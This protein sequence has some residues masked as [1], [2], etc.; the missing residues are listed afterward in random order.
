MIDAAVA[1]VADPVS[2]AAAPGGPEPWRPGPPFSGVPAYQLCRAYTVTGDLDA[3]ALR[4]AWHTVAQRHTALRHAVAGRGGRASDPVTGGGGLAVARRGPDEH[5]VTLRLHQAVTDERSLAVMLGELSAHYAARAHGRALPAALAVWP[6]QYTDPALRH[7][8]P[9]GPRRRALLS[10]WTER[11]TP[12][13]AGLAIPTDRPRPRGA[14]TRGGTL[15]FDWGP[16]PAARLAALCERSAVTP[17]AVLLA[18]FQALLA[19]F[20]DEPRTAVGVPASL[21]PARPEA[22]GV[23]GPYRNHLV[24]STD[25]GGC[26]TFRELA[27]RVAQGVRAAFDH[28]ELPYEQLLREL[29]ADDDVRRR[30]P[31]CDALFVHEP[32]DTAELR[33]PGVRVRRRT[34]DNATARTDLTLTVCQD[35]PVLRGSL[36]YRAALW[37]PPSAAAL[38]E[39]LR[40]LLTAA[41]ERPD[42]PLGELPLESAQFLRGAVRAADRTAVPPVREPVHAQVYAAARR[43]PDATA[44]TGGGDTVS[45]AALRRRAR[46]VTEALTARG[47]A[48][49][50]VAVRLDNGPDQAATVLG[51]FAAGAHALCL[52]TGR[53]GERDRAVLTAAAPAC[54]VV[55][56]ARTDDDLV[57]WYQTAHHGQVLA[58]AALA[59]DESGAES[60]SG[61]PG[62][63][64]SGADASALDRWAYVTHTS[65][66]T[67]TPKGIP[68]THR[69][70]AQFLAWFAA[71]FRL[72]PGARMAQWAAPGYDASL[73]EMGA[74][75][76]SGA[77][78]CTVPDKI[79]AHPEKLA[80]WLAAERITHFQTVPSFARQLLTAATATT[81]GG[82][83]PLTGL[84]H[85]LLAGEALTGELAGGLRAA[86]PGVRLVNL[87]GATETIL[88]TWHEVTGP[89]HGPVPI[90]RSIP[91]RQVLVLDDADRPCPTGV[92]GHIVVRGPYLTPGYAGGAG[93]HDDAAFR[94]L[95]SLD[96]GDAAAGGRCYRSGDLGRRRRDGALEFRGR[97]DARVKFLGV[98][99]ELTDIEAALA[100]H[101]SVTDCAVVAL[102]GPDG[103]VSRLVAHV[104]PGR[105][106]G[107][108]P[109]GS[110]AEW[111]AVLRR[112]FG[113][114]M[115][116]VSF[117]TLTGLPRNTGGKVDRRRLAEAADASVPSAPPVTRSLTLLPT[118]S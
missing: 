83:T 14:A 61:T 79:R 93:P 84:S 71:E 110:A 6:R 101:P 27:D 28:R 107:G 46:A 75:L 16:G 8:A 40:T 41:L 116:P 39:Q 112:R 10:W 95:D 105:A 12:P 18:A 51:A 98:R 31:L 111:R 32:A 11:L 88:A 45:Y 69:T 48:G 53:S 67:G 97:A 108:E 90:G 20:A 117:T 115:L 59:A 81:G 50:A 104:V 34:V 35:S 55:D 73:V 1:P 63:T 36:E 72:G 13:P 25:V 49:R 3:D 26:G 9:D 77:T 78:L 24:I 22:D 102:T 38:L 44:V 52:G 106:P 21:R 113:K 109:L 37:D 76:T 80:D 94:P 91:G 7:H 92:T 65:G 23:V 99:I 62:D 15:S 33:L 29:G 89:V 30:L 58:L 4:A 70:F 5:L 85:L 103:L 82:G 64:P 87:Y 47:V 118:E 68:Q 17:Y 96:A 74:A 42:A 54:L 86:L 57:T 19:R 60:A 66:S 2:E 100:A 114:A 43:T 56:T